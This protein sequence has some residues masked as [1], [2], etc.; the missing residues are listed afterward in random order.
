M[1]NPFDLLDPWLMIGGV[2]LLTF[3]FLAVFVWN[4]PRRR[5]PL[6]FEAARRIPDGLTTE[7]PLVV[8]A[9]Q[10]SGAFASGRPP[11]G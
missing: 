5:E 4:S 2:A 10:R 6:V 3:I 11:Q 8:S 1:L 7:R 9:A